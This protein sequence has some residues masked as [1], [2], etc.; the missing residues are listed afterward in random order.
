MDDDLLAGARSLAPRARALAGEGERGRRLAPELIASMRQ[1]GLFRMLVPRALGGLEVAPATFV[2][3][4]EELGAADGAAGW[5]AM[6][7]ATTGLLSAYLEPAAAAEIFGDPQVMAVGVVAPRGRARVAEGGH[8][9]TG[10][11]AF[12]SGSQHA[13]W[14]CAGAVVIDGDT[15]VAG[16]GPA[17]G[18]ATRVL[19]LP[20]S[21]CELH[22]TWSVSGLRGTGSHDFSV[23]DRFVPAARSLALGVDRPRH[24]G[25]LYAF[26]LFGLLAMGVAA[27][28]LGIARTAISALV[29]LAG[30]K[31]MGEG[32]RQ[33][34]DRPQL[35]D[36]VAQAEAEVGAARA[37][38]QAQLA[39]A[40]ELAARGEAL[41]PPVLGRVRLAATHATHAAAR[42][43]DMMYTAGGG[44]S[45]Y[46]TC[47]LERCFRDV[48]VATQHLMVAVPSYG[49]AGRTLLGLP[50]DPRML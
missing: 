3:V 16:P 7:A 4:I 34:R 37:Y 24:P 42:A 47:P 18:P 9:L 14:I 1:L 2:D 28:A 20:A 39:A 15:A 5:I 21:E 17:P 48:H 38:L 19:L 12:G 13:G 30:H 49:L 41:A 29:E 25:A 45:I 31:A 36:T 33:L 35:A 8:R 26:P 50:V 27:V 32:G 10:Q 44:S 11:W 43:V 46:E 23:T 22:D 40:A 6:V